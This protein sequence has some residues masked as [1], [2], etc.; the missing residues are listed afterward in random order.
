MLVFKSDELPELAKGKGNKL[1]QLPKGEN[2]RAIHCFKEGEKVVVEAG[3]Y[4][5]VF[6]PT[7]IE[8]AFANRAKKG[9]VLP[10]TLKKTTSIFTDH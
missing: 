10:R 4:Q 7:A 1:I 6:G 5:K 8:E 2:V 9:V 3:K